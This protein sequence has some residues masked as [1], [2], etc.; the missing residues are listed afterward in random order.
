MHGEHARVQA[1][2][3][4]AAHSRA[5]ALNSSGDRVPAPACAQ[6]A[7]VSDHRKVEGH[8]DARTDT[9]SV[10]DVATPPSAGDVALRF[11][12]PPDSLRTGRKTLDRVAREGQGHGTGHMRGWR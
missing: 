1:L 3:D 8:R 4:G 12:E 2:R 7:R 11:Y 5:P 10:G 9:S 6:R